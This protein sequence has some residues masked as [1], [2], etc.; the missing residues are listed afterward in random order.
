MFAR[1]IRICVTDVLEEDKCERRPYTAVLLKMKGLKKYAPSTF[2]LN[3][4]SFYHLLLQSVFSNNFDIVEYFYNNEKLT[5]EESFFAAL[6]ELTERFFFPDGIKDFE[7]IIEREKEVK[8]DDELY[9]NLRS[10]AMLCSSL[11]EENNNRLFSLVIG[12]EYKIEYELSEKFILTGRI[13]ILAWTV[14]RKAVRVIELKTGKSSLRDKRQVLTYSEI[15]RKSYPNIEIIPE[16]WYLNNDEKKKRILDLPKEDIELKR[17]SNIVS[18]VERVKSEKQL[19]GKIMKKA[20]CKE[21][22][23]MCDFINEIFG[24]NKKITKNEE[25]VWKKILVKQEQ[26]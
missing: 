25:I 2:A 20:F 26:K 15:I 24:K 19:P 7:C 5:I 6:N 13:D 11:V 9:F 16:L 18:I 12:V 14:D 17:I 22:C 23:K 8:Y 10:L 3:A 21:K 1:P 4:G